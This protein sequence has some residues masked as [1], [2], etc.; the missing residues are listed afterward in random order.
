MQAKLYRTSQHGSNLSSYHHLLINTAFEP[1]TRPNVRTVPV[2]GSVFVGSPNLR[3]MPVS[4]LL[5]KRLYFSPLIVERLVQSNWYP[6]VSSRYES[7]RESD[8]ANKYL[9][10]CVCGVDFA[11]LSLSKCRYT[12]EG[13]NI[14]STSLKALVFQYG[15]DQ[16]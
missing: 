1:C 6:R 14:P 9:T 3:I 10:G 8:P 16:R 12:T 13:L 7:Y 11:F 2:G 15:L 4:M 5:R